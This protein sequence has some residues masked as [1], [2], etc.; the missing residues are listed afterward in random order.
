MI[1]F[2]RSYKLM[3]SVFFYVAQ[4]LYLHVKNT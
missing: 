3:V 1:F 2:E 4:R